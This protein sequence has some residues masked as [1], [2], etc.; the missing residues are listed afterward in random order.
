MSSTSKI[1]SAIKEMRTAIQKKKSMDVNDFYF[2]EDTEMLMEKMLNV[3][4]EYKIVSLQ[5]FYSAIQNI[6]IKEVDE[7]WRSKYAKTPITRDIRKVMYLFEES[8]L[9]KNVR[10]KVEE[11]DSEFNV[12]YTIK[13]FEQKLKQNDIEIPK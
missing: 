1:I 7:N 10:I 5:K 2:L 9:I 13:R 6:P 12:E 8:G 11:W 3:L 4:M